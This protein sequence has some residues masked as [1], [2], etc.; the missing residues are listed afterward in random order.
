MEKEGELGEKGREGGQAVIVIDIRY[1]YAKF[2]E[3]Q[4]FYIWKIK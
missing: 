2:L 4:S 1:C 3:T